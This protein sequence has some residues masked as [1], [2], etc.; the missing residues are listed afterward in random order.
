MVRYKLKTPYRDGT[1]HVIFEAIGFHIKA[2]D[3]CQEST[4][5]ERRVSMTWAQ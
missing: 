4:S 2:G 3:A 5:E 1:T